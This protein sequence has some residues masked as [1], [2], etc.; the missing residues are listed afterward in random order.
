[1]SRV[2]V[3]VGLHKTGS[4][5]IQE[6]LRVNADALGARGVAT[7][8]PNHDLV[9]RL[10][11]GE[12]TALLATATELLARADI[13]VLTSENLSSMQRPLFLD[14]LAALCAAIP[15]VEVVV[16][17]RR[18]ADAVYSHWLEAIKQGTLDSFPAWCGTMLA[19]HPMLPTFDTARV[20]DLVDGTAARLRIGC[21]DALAEPYPGDVVGH[22]VHRVLGVDEIDLAPGEAY[23][24]PSL[25]A[26]EVNRLISLFRATRGTAS[27][28]VIYG[29]YLRL[30]ERDDL[31]A[32]LVQ[33]EETIVSASR[34][35]RVERLDRL[36][37]PRDAEL[38]AA[39]P[40]LRTD[41]GPTWRDINDGDAT[42]R[43]Y[44][45]D[46]VYADDEIRSAI[47]LISGLLGDW[48][49]R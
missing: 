16:Y 41:P 30:R 31:R 21:Y 27:N 12:R 13:A 42:E 49:P 19:A 23:A 46:A 40:A 14:G 22:F 10:R 29:R 48:P 3:H 36:F 6:G 43:R 24:S 8:S 47:E 32:D 4:T 38:D 20:L 11:A 18:R 2:V 35:Y 37:A 17:I 26:A 15:D 25:G 1:M 7:D 45:P 28:E 33:L 39:L 9:P 34:P 44:V 5:A